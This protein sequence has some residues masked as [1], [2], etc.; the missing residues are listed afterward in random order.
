MG[1]RFIHPSAHMEAKDN[2]NALLA[3]GTDGVRMA[4]CFFNHGGLAILREHARALKHP[5]SFVVVSL[6]SPTDLT[7]VDELHRVAPGHVYLHLGWV[8]PRE[9][10]GGAALMHSKICLVS[11]GEARQLWV[12]SHNLTASAMSGANIEA[13]LLYDTTREDAVIADAEQHLQECRDSAELFEPERLLEYAA[14]QTRFGSRA[15][16]TRA[17]VVVLHAEEHVPLGD[18]PAVI[19]VRLPTAEFDAVAKTGNP[20]HLFLHSRGTLGTASILHRGVRRFRG[21]IIEDN[22]T[23]RHAGGGSASTMTR[24]THWLEFG[25]IPTLIAPGTSTTEPVTQAAI[26]VE[27]QQPARA[28]E[29]VYSVVGHRTRVEAAE[30]ATGAHEAFAPSALRHFFTEDSRDG[31]QLVFTPRR[32]RRESPPV[33]V[34][35]GTPIPELADLEISIEPIKRPLD[36]YFF[37][38]PFRVRTDDD[39]VD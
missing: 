36:P 14:L 27:P 19:H 10:K 13:A 22:W 1:L 28:D 8:T 39:A 18:L 31:D 30:S 32:H 25:K 23:E 17:P 21:R 26:L 7:A 3:G 29:Y 16:S 35:E 20:V 37:K 15:G 4:V 11:S 12:G 38:S 34:Y 6:E 33:R 9:I 2:F 24:A 5:D